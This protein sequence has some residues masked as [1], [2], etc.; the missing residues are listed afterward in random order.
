MNEEPVMNT[1]PD[2]DP[3]LAPSADSK[4]ENR[5][6]MRVGKGLVILLVGL[7]ILAFILYLMIGFRAVSHA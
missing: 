2:N 4:A 7:A 5:R 3:A 6:K 1:D